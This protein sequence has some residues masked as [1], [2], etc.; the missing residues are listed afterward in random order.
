MNAP[1]R[2]AGRAR[3][4]PHLA[5]SLVL[6][7]GSLLTFLGTWEGD[8]QL[9]VYADTLAG[10]LP[11]VCRG[12]TRH[13]TS[14][15]IVVGERW[16]REKCEAEEMA[17]VEKVQLQVAACFKVLPPQHVFEAASSHAWN[18][19]APATCSSQAMAAFNRGDW[20]LGCRRLSRGDDGRVVWSFTS[21]IGRDGKKVLTFVKGL[22]NRRAAETAL[23]L[24]E[25]P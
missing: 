16:T 11:T 1:Q 6:A 17:A 19:G 23:C 15:P 3:Y 21:H 5:G 18:L 14:T 9:T 25:H 4:F 20:A 12:L 10:G 7:T 2:R 22:A 13:V 24:K 8:D